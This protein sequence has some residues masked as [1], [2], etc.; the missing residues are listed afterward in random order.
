MAHSKLIIKGKEVEWPSV[1]EIIALLN[2]P[3]LA[4]WRGKIGNA[5]ADRIAR[6]S[7]AVGTEV[8]ELIEKTLGKGLDKA[9]ST[10]KVESI[11]RAWLDWWQSQ[12]YLVKELEIKV[13]SKKKKF[14]GSF[15]AVLM[16]GDTPILVDWKITKSADHFRYLQLAGYAYAYYEM[17]KV[18]INDGLIVMIH[19]ETLKVSVKQV[20]NLWGYTPLF[21]ALRKL[22]E[23][24]KTGKLKG[25]KY[26]LSGRAKKTS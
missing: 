18:K 21:L 4:I 19:P 8:H 13:Y 1:T 20:D 11:Y 9:P 14:H 12:S 17:F 3:F 26:D 10:T 2:K 7:A 24:V 23:F 5:E 15:D 22:Y 6:A 16:F 25:G